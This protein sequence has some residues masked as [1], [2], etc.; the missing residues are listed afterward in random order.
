[1]IEFLFYFYHVS[2]IYSMYF[3]LT[4]YIVIINIYD[5]SFHMLSELQAFLEYKSSYESSLRKKL[6]L[7]FIEVQITCVT[8]KSLL[9]VWYQFSWF[10]WV[11]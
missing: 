1:M 7:H 5:V 3:V 6:Y 9:F 11:G 8:V 10:S 4:F 2:Q